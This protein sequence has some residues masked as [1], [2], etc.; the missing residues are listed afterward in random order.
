M[1]EPL[2]HD[3]T[4]LLFDKQAEL[5][6]IHPQANDLAL[7]TALIGSPIPFHPGAI[8]YYRERGVWKE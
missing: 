6:R 1:D 7:E 5:A 2:A 3:I 4:R 8:R